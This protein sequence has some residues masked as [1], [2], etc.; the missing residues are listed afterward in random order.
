MKKILLVIAA[1]VCFY[2]CNSTEYR[3]RDIVK[4][5]IKD[6]IGDPN[7][8]EAGEFGELYTV[9]ATKFD[10]SEY[11]AQM[12]QYANERDEY[13]RIGNSEKANEALNKI[14]QLQEQMQKDIEA[15]TPNTEVYA[16]YVIHTFRAKNE[17]GALT[18]YFYKYAVDKSFSTVLHKEE[19]TDEWVEMERYVEEVL[20]SNNEGYFDWLINSL[21]QLGYE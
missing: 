18:K 19:I 15:F 5:Y 21:Q 11:D 8:Y 6:S 2:G 13:L 10:T 7:S 20:R 3:V 16:Y 14:S 1:I 12:K 17:Y 4:E 9:Y